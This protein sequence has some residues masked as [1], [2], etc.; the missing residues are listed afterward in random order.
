VKPHL[1]FIRFIGLIVPRRLRADWRQEWEAE[2]RYRERLLAE[3]E[4]L[5][6]RNKLELLRR[7]TSA[8][9]DAL[10][11]QPQRL[12]EEMFQDLRFGAR[13]LLK[14]K[15]FTA[16][17]ILTLAL[18]IGAN[19]AIFS[20]I[21]TLVLRSLP[22]LHPE[23]L[24]LVSSDK[25]TG[26]EVFG[27]RGRSDTFPY[28]LYKRLRE[29]N[30]KL[31]GL[32]AAGTV[33]Q[34]RMV[35]SGIG[36]IETEFIRA[37][38]V[39]GNF[40]SVLGVSA[41]AGRTL[42]TLD[43][44]VG[45]PQAVAVIS[46]GFWQ[47]RFGADPGV[48]GKS[49]KFDDLT[50]T[51]VGVASPGFFG[52]EVGANPDLWWPMQLIPQVDSG[53]WG[54]RLT[55]PSSFWLR[56]IGRMPAGANRMQVQAQL[57]ALFQ[58]ELADFAAQDGSSW[59]A[60]MRRFIME[61]NLE[62]VPGDTGWSSLW[63]QFHRPLSI[64]LVV[65]VLV[66][67]IACANIASLLLA[68]AAARHREFSVRSALGA[69][70]FRLV[71][72][73]LTESLLLSVLGALLGL[74]LSQWGTQALLAIMRLKGDPIA[75]NLAPD[76]RV[77]L[78]T[79]VAALLTGLLFGLAPALRSSRTDLATELKGT[80]GS[81]AGAGL[82]NRLNQSLVVTQVA[83]S[84][85]LL[86]G[87]GL[88]VRTLEK[89]KGLDAGFNRENILMFDLDFTAKQDA[90]SHTRIHKELLSR[91][92]TLP[93][94]QAASLS[95][96][97]LLSGGGWGEQ[98]GAD[99]YIARPDE[100][101]NCHGMLISPR[102]FETL[103]TPILMG[104]DLG[105]Q[106]ERSTPIAPR[107]ALI[108]R[109]MAR[110]YFGDANPLGRHIFFLDRP[111]EK[112]E[113]VGVVADMKYQSLRDPAPPTYYMPAFPGTTDVKLTFTLR[114]TSDPGPLEPG[115]HAA[116]RETDPTVR[117]RGLQTL[118]NL[119]DIS[120]HQER[121]LAQLGG[122]FSIFALALACL[123]IYGVLSFAVV[124]RTR[125]IGLR[126]ALGAERKDVV[127]LVVGQGLKLASL[128]IALGLIAALGVTRLVAGLLYGV[129]PSDPVAF[130]CVTLL[131]LLVAALA[132]WLP[133][134]RAAKV[135]PMIALRQE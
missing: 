58:Q 15:G 38:E 70:R 124:Q 27:S 97:Y 56:I 92:E 99:G 101:L 35:A 61:R 41:I 53:H 116:I 81:I 25:R 33:S 23:E 117:V 83:L 94:V 14:H 7:S 103:S 128:G 51:I 20:V 109:A 115:I 114:T 76:T 22:V 45:N 66:L 122:F 31:A 85:V 46:H 74:L 44:Q 2:L 48:V 98:I 72:Q 131:L 67:L 108:N 55:S 32:F 134:R 21:N 135:D 34:R 54:Q 50:L 3:W 133:A 96:F 80:S 52:I 121:V 113:I 37:Q 43:D 100:D 17:A 65:T 60:D 59:S 132:S 1:W 110:R 9:W 84:L 112:Y 87:A 123:G 89:L 104:R 93:G 77:L 130:I 75:F 105:A 86:V 129:T 12:E 16:V 19:T 8:F 26:H 68:R 28:T 118:D 40:F 42:T 57:D 29:G 120:L 126:I 4:R 5:D 119:V 106:D 6:W 107:T 49:I 125:E 111:Q 11:I 13:M 95:T 88:F 69:G 18:G 90:A 39:T 47:R 102:F 91:F 36:G 78:F 127:V 10:L 64:L 79:T 30:H 82:R 73:M 24:V 63:L 62:L 71:R